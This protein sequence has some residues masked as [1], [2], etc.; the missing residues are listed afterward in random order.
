M[1]HSSADSCA[2][3]KLNSE[4]TRTIAL[5]QSCKE[6]AVLSNKDKNTLEK[7]ALQIRLLNRQ[8]Q[9]FQTCLES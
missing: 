2:A 9:A 1:E 6:K 3:N 7:M 8:L 4:L 5:A